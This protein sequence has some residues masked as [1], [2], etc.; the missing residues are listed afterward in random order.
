MGTLILLFD[1][2]ISFC[3]KNVVRYLSIAINEECHVFDQMDI[4]KPWVFLICRY[5]QKLKIDI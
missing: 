2:T 4:N 1:E 5:G 3:V